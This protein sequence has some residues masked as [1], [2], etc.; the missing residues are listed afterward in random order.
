MY[1]A[2]SGLSYGVCVL[3]LRLQPAGSFSCSI[4]TL[5]HSTWDL[6]SC[7]EIEHRLPALGEES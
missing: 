5:G 2:V 7:P 1:L 4:Q 6:V 3:D